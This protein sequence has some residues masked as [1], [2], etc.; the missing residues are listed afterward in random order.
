MPS[1]NTIFYLEHRELDKQLW[2]RC[3]DN[4]DNGLIYAYSF[5]LDQMADC[6]DA[7]V[8]GNYEAVMPL[9]KRQKFGVSYLFQPSLTPTLGVFG[10][11]ITAIQVED[12]LNSIPTFFKLWDISLNHFNFFKSATYKKIK[13]SNYILSLNNSYKNIYSNYHH[14]IIRDIT[15]A[16]KEGLSVSNN[17]PLQDIV[18]I[19]K[20]EFPLF[21]KVEPHLFDNLS[22]IYEHSP[23]PKLTS[24]VYSR[25]GILLSSCAFLFSHNRAY[26]W[27]VGN[28]PE[29][30]I[31]R[32]SAFL[33]DNFIREHAESNLL[34]DFEG[35][36]KESI[37]FFYKKFGG[38]LEDYVSIY[39]NKLPFPFK[40]LKPIP[41]YYRSFI[42]VY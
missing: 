15:K 12:F 9:P 19:C 42:S 22:L 4:A 26:Y 28:N 33:L 25:E 3:I 23:Y 16:K 13:R 27:L 34:L 1:N 35:S 41:R 18:T 8:L 30:R 37:A 32:A 5:Y 39:N 7:L 36:D 20:R 21:M 29:G 6:W 24:G 38:I 11:Q 10:N 40:L 2:D 31:Y 17:I 14:N